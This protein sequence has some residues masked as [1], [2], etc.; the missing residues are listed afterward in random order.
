MRD[1]IIL[2]IRLPQ[3]QGYASFS[4]FY[5]SAGFYIFSVSF[6]SFL[7]SVVLCLANTGSS[8]L[9]IALLLIYCSSLITAQQLEYLNVHLQRH[10]A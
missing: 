2:P 8:L 10:N 6:S 3:E 5:I 1:D 4:P 7:L 9:L